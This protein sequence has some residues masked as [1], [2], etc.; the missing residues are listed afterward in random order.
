MYIPKDYQYRVGIRR[1]FLPIFRKFW[2][3]GHQVEMF[4][5]KTYLT[6]RQPDGALLSLPL[7]A[8]GRWVIKVYPEYESARALQR[9]PGPAQ[10][11]PNGV[12]TGQ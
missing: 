7:P 1:R 2:V 11:Q 12:P 4:G 8:L 9:N 6:L 5:D 10:E 3:V